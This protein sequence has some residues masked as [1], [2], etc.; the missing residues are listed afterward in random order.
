MTN[1]DQLKS[2]PLAVHAFFD[3]RLGFIR[4]MHALQKVSISAG[5]DLA[6][7]SNSRSWFDFRNRDLKPTSTQSL[8]CARARAVMILCWPGEQE[9]MVYQFLCSSFHICLPH[10]NPELHTHKHVQSWTACMHVQSSSY[11]IWLQHVF[12]PSFVQCLPHVRCWP[13]LNDDAADLMWS[14]RPR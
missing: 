11:R 12:D 7:I 8:P 9:C 3:S 6:T 4:K 10:G 1:R 14:F 2:T 13:Q 5:H